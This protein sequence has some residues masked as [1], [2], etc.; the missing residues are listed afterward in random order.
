VEDHIFTIAGNQTIIWDYKNDKLVKNLPDTPLHPRCFP[1]S[2]TSVLLPLK[3]PNYNPTVLVCG[4]SSGDMPNPKA[5]DDCWKI[6]PLDKNAAWVEDDR[7]PNG[8]QVMSVCLFHV[9]I[10]V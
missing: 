9:R 1:S 7:L 8:P 5:L 4:G 6:D 2:A 3:Y 10:L